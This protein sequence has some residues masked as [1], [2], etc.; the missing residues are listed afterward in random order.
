MLYTYCC[1]RMPHAL[2]VLRFPGGFRPTLRVFTLIF[3][4]LYLPRNPPLHKQA[5]EQA[6]KQGGSSGGGGCTSPLLMAPRILGKPHVP[7]WQPPSF[8]YSTLHPLTP[9]PVRQKLSPRKARLAN[10]ALHYDIHTRKRISKT[11]MN[12]KPD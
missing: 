12:L 11:L 3:L 4:P 5:S 10:V 7:R 6:S 8:N 1:C 2:M 9:T